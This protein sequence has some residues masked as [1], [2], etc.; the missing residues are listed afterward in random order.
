MRA[1]T[2]IILLAVLLLTCCAI[3]ASAESPQAVPE[4][5]QEACGGC[6]VLTPAQ[7][8]EHRAVLNDLLRRAFEAGKR[9]QAQTC[10]SLI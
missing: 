10:A 2:L 5:P 8:Q 3:P 1:V 4:I 7:V 6:V 9:Y